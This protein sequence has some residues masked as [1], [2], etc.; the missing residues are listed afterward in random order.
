MLRLRSGI[1]LAL[2]VGVAYAEDAPR[3]AEPPPVEPAPAEP[4]PAPAL[5]TGERDRR[6]LE[7]VRARCRWFQL[8]R[9]FGTTLTVDHT[10]FLKATSAAALYA[11]NFDF[12]D[13][14]AMAA[15]PTIE[16]DCGGPPAAP[17]ASNCFNELAALT[18]NTTNHID[19]DPMLTNPKDVAAPNWK[20]AVSSVLAGCGAPPA[21]LDTTATFC[22]A[23]GAVD[24][25]AS[26]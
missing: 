21:G 13:H 23:I 15:T 16:N 9:P 3:A 22:G 24:C 8:A 14:D 5:A 6:V 25:P 11:N 7:H 20:P 17:G 18:A 12:F 10:Y 19:A 2:L 1:V 26:N 4:A